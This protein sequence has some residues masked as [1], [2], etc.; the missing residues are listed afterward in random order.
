LEDTNPSTHHQDAKEKQLTAT[1]ATK[2]EELNDEI[3]EMDVS[4]EAVAETSKDDRI[5][6][7]LEGNKDD[8]AHTHVERNK[9]DRMQGDV[10]L[11]K[12][13]QIQGHVDLNKDDQIQGHVEGNKDDQMQGHEDLNKDNQMQ[14]HVEMNKDDRIQG[15]RDVNKDEELNDHV[16]TNGQIEE[17]NDDQSNVQTEKKRFVSVRK[18][19]GPEE[20]IMIVDALTAGNIGES[21]GRN[22][23]FNPNSK[24]ILF[25]CLAESPWKVRFNK[26]FN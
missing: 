23:L 11:N 10:D 13:D 1:M 8:R 19:F 22:F 7:H 4:C 12:D 9:D 3:E 5:Q 25:L 20:D 17:M 18:Y 26:H 15:Q 2:L 24:E 14:G 16:E 6:V 21:L